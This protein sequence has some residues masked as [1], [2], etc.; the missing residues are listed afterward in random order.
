MSESL[1]NS[2]NAQAIIDN[3]TLAA[4]P[5]R[6]GDDLAVFAVPQGGHV[7]QVDVGAVLD[8]YRDRPRRKKG[9]FAAQDA[10]S[11]ARYLTKHADGNSEVWAD[12]VGSTVVGVINAH[13]AASDGEAG[14]SDH[15]VTYRVQHTD[16]WKAWANRNGTLMGQA[17]FAELIEDRATDIVTP[18]AADMLEL[19][20]TFQATVGVNFESSKVLSSGE[21]QLEYRETVEAKAGRAGRLE[22]PKEFQLA[23]KPFEG[24]ETY[25]VTARFRYRITDGNL[26]IGFRLERPE[27]VLRDA[28]EGVV[29]AIEGQVEQPVFRGVPS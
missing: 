29:A 23:L 20:Q 9:A 25:K 14:W 18:S 3:A 17:D 24:A 10:A 26:R 21:R 4:E 2:G 27:D 8:K 28:F 16:A 6:F 22:V 15:R 19:A 12:A 1:D 7:E 5:S 11:F 13:Q